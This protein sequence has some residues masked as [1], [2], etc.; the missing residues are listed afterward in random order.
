MK[1]R[2]PLFFVLFMGVELLTSLWVWQNQ[3]SHGLVDVYQYSFFKF[4]M[5]R[6]LAWVVTACIML[7]LFGLASNV[8][9]RQSKERKDRP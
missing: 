8:F 5:E 3:P 1:K 9:R 2:I 4:E 6:L 7:A